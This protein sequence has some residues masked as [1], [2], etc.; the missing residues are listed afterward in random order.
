MRLPNKLLLEN[1]WTNIQALKTPCGSQC[2]LDKAQTHLGV[3]HSEFKIFVEY[4]MI[5]AY[6]PDVV[7]SNKLKKVWLLVMQLPLFYHKIC[8]LIF[9]Q[10]EILEEVVI[11]YDPYVAPQRV[12]E[13]RIARG[14]DYH[15]RFFHSDQAQV[16]SVPE[17]QQKQ[18]PKQKQKR[19]TEAAIHQEPTAKR[20]KPTSVPVNRRRTGTGTGTGTGND[21]DNDNDNGNSPL[22]LLKEELKNGNFQRLLS[23]LQ[24]YFDW[25]YFYLKIGSFKGIPMPVGGWLY[26][27]KK[28]L[29]KEKS[30]G[31]MPVFKESAELNRDYF[32][33]EKSVIDFVRLNLSEQPTGTIAVAEHAAVVSA[34]DSVSTS[35]C[36]TPC[37]T[38]KVAGSYGSTQRKAVKP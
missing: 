2:W 18:R 1:T 28:S 25:T 30:R 13:R 32:L 19:Q 17:P 37:A 6:D 11:D 12:V 10:L 23:V 34:A 22:G 15:K 21:N 8:G 29:A 14:K 33:D 36:T 31:A 5:T 27:P 38:T 7:M 26:Y 3:D 24:T 35:S 4:L 20:A 9:D 16:R